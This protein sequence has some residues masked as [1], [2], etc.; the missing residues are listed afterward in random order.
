[1]KEQNKQLNLNLIFLIVMISSGIGFTVNVLT[2]Y[3]N[4][5]F[6]ISFGLPLLFLLFFRKYIFVSTE[7]KADVESKPVSEKIR[8]W[9]YKLWSYIGFYLAGMGIW[10]LIKITLDNLEYINSKYDEWY[11]SIVLATII[12]SIKG[13]KILYWWFK[14]QS[15]TRIFNYKEHLINQNNV[16]LYIYIAYLVIL[17]ANYS[18]LVFE[19]TSLWIN[20]FATYVAF[21]RV[22]SNWHLLRNKDFSA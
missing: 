10:S 16:R 9:I 18:G 21:D 12:M 19:E 1:M 6:L 15:I 8:I 2:G 14:L 4:Y 11:I 22:R 13:D 3:N 17:F 5:I 7:K 20:T